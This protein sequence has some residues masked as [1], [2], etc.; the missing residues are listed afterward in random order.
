MATAGRPTS[1]HELAKLFDRSEKSGVRELVGHKKKARAP[2]AARPNSAPAH[3]VV[4]QWFA[5]Q[6]GEQLRVHHVGVVV[7]RR[8]DLRVQGQEP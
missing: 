3:L 5:G 8:E 2:S 4:E 7:L 1:P 6:H